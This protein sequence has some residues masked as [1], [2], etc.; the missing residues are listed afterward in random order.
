VPGLLLLLVLRSE[1]EPHLEE[2]GLPPL[3]PGE[4][5]PDVPRLTLS[6]ARRFLEEGRLG[7]GPEAVD[8]LVSGA[9]R[10]DD[11]P[12]LVRPITVNL[13]G[14]ILAEG[15]RVRPESA[16]R[17]SRQTRVTLAGP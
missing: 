15:E 16:A 7:L 1:Y 12:G 10:L 13:L 5:W 9:A 14:H 2:M 6:A 8:A 11:T 3:R 17:E 4:N